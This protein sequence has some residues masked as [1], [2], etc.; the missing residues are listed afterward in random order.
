MKRALQ[1][2][3]AVGG[4]IPVFAGLVLIQGLPGYPLGG[5]E[6]NWW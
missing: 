1:I 4:M 3:V 6:W 2:A 5:L